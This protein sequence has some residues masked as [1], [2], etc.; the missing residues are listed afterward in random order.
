MKKWLIALFCFVSLLCSGYA[1]E[2]TK[3]KNTKESIEVEC[4]KE[5]TII[6]DSNK[7]TGYE[8]QLTG[9]LD[10]ELVS[11]VSSDYKIENTEFVGV[12]SMEIW[13]FKALKEGETE[14]NF[15]YV[16]PWEKDVV[17]AITKKYTVIIKAKERR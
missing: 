15:Q 14:I 13:T 3:E 5:F 17:P 1:Q 6:L 7:T 10:K 12:G 8:W 2:A 16:R 9:D 4:E 11:F